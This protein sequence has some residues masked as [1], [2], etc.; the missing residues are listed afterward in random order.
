VW[1]PDPT[2]ELRS[3]SGELELVGRARRPAE[4]SSGLDFNGAF[5]RSLEDFAAA[6]REHREPSLSGSEGRRSVALIEA[7]YRAAEPLALPW[8]RPPQLAAAP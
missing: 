5:L 4:S 3:A 1:D 7:C 2:F 6:I 8:E